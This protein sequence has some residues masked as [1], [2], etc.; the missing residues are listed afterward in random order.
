MHDN[1]SNQ[2]PACPKQQILSSSKG[3]ISFRACGKGKTILFL[4]GL[5]GSSKAWAFQL[6]DFSDKYQATAWDAPGYGAS[7]EVPINIDAYVQALGTL[8]DS[9][10]GEPVILLG[11]SMGGTVA[12]RFA[13]IHPD[14]VEKLILSCTHPGY[15]DPQT[16]PMSEKFEK[17]MQELKEIGKEAYGLNRARDLLPFPDVTEQVLAYA[18][19]V[20][21]ETNPEGLRRATRMLQLADNRP[22]LPQLKVPTLILTGEVDKVVQPKLQEDLLKLTPHQQHIVMPGIAHAPYFQKPAYYN[23]LIRE[24]LSAH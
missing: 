19:L 16:A 21:S 6:N 14:K 20:A 5:L 7:D 10:S 13:A 11:H 3:K 9:L 2:V 15:G 8:I 24:F 22:L 4:H 1:S 12:S 23:A 18:A 17:R